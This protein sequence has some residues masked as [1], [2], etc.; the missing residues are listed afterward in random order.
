MKTH[1]VFAIM[2]GLLLVFLISRTKKKNLAFENIIQQAEA[3]SKEPYREVR[4]VPS[5]LLRGLNYDQY[6]DIR[7]K[8]EYTLW[9]R[10]GLPFQAKF[11]FTG[12]LHS[13]P[14]TIFQVNRE[15]PGQLRFSPEF[16]DFGKNVIP[17]SEAAKGGYAGF[18][19]HYP[20]N[21][22]DFLDEVLVFLDASYFR[23][24][25]KDQQW[26]ISARGLSIG[27]LRKEESPDFTTFWLVEPPPGATDMK[28]YALLEGRS[29]SGAYEFHVFPGAET[30]IEIRAVVFPR[31]DIKD[32]GFAPLTSMF[33]FGENT[34]NTFGNYRPEVHDSDGLQIERGNGEWVW[35]PLSWSKQL[36]V[37]VFEDENPR[38]FG[39]L[40][41]DR[42][43]TH[44]QDME[45][46][47]HQRPSVWVR[48]A[49]KWGKGAVQLVQIPTANEYKDNVVA[50]WQPKGG[51]KKGGR[52]EINYSL[53]WFGEKDSIPPV[54]RCLFTR[55]DS[56]DAP[57]FRIF[58]L[59]FDGG[60]LSKLPADARVTADTWIGAGG[61][62]KDVVVQKNNYNDSWRVTFIASSD[63]LDK[64]LELRCSMTVD[65][66]PLTETW[67]YTWMN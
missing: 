29:V 47:Y 14:V 16:F 66:R 23:A 1:I 38:G 22:P 7:W 44:Y 20:L 35:R 18:R 51:M 45:A 50:Y 54:G 15:A 40:Q 46:R 63:Q 31:R 30:R 39:L 33:W 27:I 37:A 62:I 2:A 10:L 59:D 8:D 6:R 60:E 19:I 36:Q 25:A 17:E 57:Y 55:I 26:G 4:E 9:R 13:K 28:I 34:S 56:Q 11:L 58:V 41:R 48:P 65:G 24:V 12:H 32:P 3:L 67:T 49:G 61:G 5:A 21:R 43:F 42:D 64:P 52:Y 53:S